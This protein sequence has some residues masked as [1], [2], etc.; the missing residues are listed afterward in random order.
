LAI[1]DQIEAADERIAAGKPA[2]QDLCGPLSD[3][4]AGRHGVAGCH[5]R[6]DGSIR[7]AKVVD[8]VDFEVAIHHRHGVLP[9]FGAGCL[10]PQTKRSGT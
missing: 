4:H 1:F 2:R 7:D 6:H 5:A 10:M 3:D 8:A 9:H